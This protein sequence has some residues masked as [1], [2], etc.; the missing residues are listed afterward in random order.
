[1]QLAYL[2]FVLTNPVTV[3]ILDILESR[4]KETLEQYFSKFPLDKRL[5]VKAITMDMWEPYHPD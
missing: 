4:K 5:K 2:C 3:E 1:M